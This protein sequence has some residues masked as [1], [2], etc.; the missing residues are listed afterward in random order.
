MLPFSS[1]DTTA[2]AR[3]LPAP[4]SAVSFSTTSF[5]AASHVAD[6]NPPR[7]LADHR[8]GDPVRM[9][10]ALERG[11]SAQAEGARVDGVV[12]I[13]L[14]LHDAPLAVPREHAAARRALAA[15]RGEPGGD[16]G[17][18]LL[19]RDDQRQDVTRWP[20]GSRPAAAAAPDAVTI[21]K[22]SR[23]FMVSSVSVVARH[24]IERRV[25]PAVVAFSLR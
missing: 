3:P 9:V 11:L 5:S 10:E 18:D 21:L 6:V 8:A 1:C 19:V 16:A 2:I 12:G 14:E 25:P 22:K 7:L 24:A 20:A 17:H 4:R 15:H 23:R 13:A